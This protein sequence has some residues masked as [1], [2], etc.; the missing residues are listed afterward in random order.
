MGARS[1]IT[2]DVDSIRFY[3]EIHGLAER[4]E[5]EDPIYSIAMPRFWELIE[6]AGVPATLFLIGADAPSYRSAFEPASKTRSEIASHSFAHDYRLTKRSAD[7]I[8]DDLRRADDALRPLSPSGK[9][10]GFRAP[11]YNTSRVLMKA[12]SDLGY[13]YDSSL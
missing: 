4:D 13:A 9:I 7:L 6:E 11:G 1:A 3:R 10:A 5:D 8:A 12:V 2:I